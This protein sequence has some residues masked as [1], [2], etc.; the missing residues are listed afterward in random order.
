M[1]ASKL[2]IGARCPSNTSFFQKKPPRS[3]LTVNKG[4]K[5][6]KW[7]NREE[8][9]LAR[10]EAKLEVTAAKTTAFK[11]LYVGL[12]ESCQEKR[13]YSLAKAMERKAR[14]LDQV[15]F[16]KEE[17]GKVLV[18]DVH[19]KR[20]WQSYFHRLLSGEGNKEIVLGELEH[21]E[22]CRDFSNYRR[23]KIE[24]V[25][26]ATRRMYRGKAT[27]PDEIPV[28]FWKYSSG[29]GLRWLII[30]FNGIFRIVKIPETWR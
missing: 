12:E 21:S 8:Y 15:K 18:E 4:P 27:G 20:R 5:E 6:K 9:K 29:A 1:T 11:S 19:I 13:L 16:V 14:D 30:L 7:A 28:N 17:D 23:I 3:L 10:K 2:N 25:F 24:E 22:G 26:E